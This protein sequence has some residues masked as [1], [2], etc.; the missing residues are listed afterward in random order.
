MEQP[1]QMSVS[2]P[3]APSIKRPAAPKL[4]YEEV[5]R[6]AR[7]SVL[8]DFTSQRDHRQRVAR[9]SALGTDVHVIPAAA[10]GPLSK[11]GSTRLLKEHTSASWSVYLYQWSIFGLTGVS[12]I[13]TAMGF[14]LTI[15]HNRMFLPVGPMM[16]VVTWRLWSSLESAWEEQRFIDNA[17][18]IRE[19]RK[20]NPMNL[21][22]KRVVVNDEE[23]E[24]PAEG[25]V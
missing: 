17:A 23:A 19:S 8:E 21:V 2:A 5:R 1:S 12:S 14:Y 3:P 25:M 18:S 24:E 11:E 6:A 9:A 20:G 16:A 7:L 15:Y 10:G 4:T 22:V 13:S